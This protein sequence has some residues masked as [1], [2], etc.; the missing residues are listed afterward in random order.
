MLLRISQYQGCSH[1]TSYLKLV[2]SNINIHSCIIVKFFIPCTASIQYGY[3]ANMNYSNKAYKPT[4]HGMSC[5]LVSVLLK[6]LCSPA[7][8]ILTALRICI[9]ITLSKPYPSFLSMQLCMGPH[10]EPN[11][12]NL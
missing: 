9:W 2:S 4:T 11:H 6:C 1:L 10:I 7:I 3:I 5:E 8:Y 12:G